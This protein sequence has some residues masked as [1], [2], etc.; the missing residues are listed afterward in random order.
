MDGTSCA[1]PLVA[2]VISLLNSARLAQNKTVL[3][4]VSPLLYR[5][6]DTSSTGNYNA[7]NYDPSSSPSSSSS[8]PSSGP[9]PFFK[10]VV[11]G[12]NRC[13]AVYYNGCCE[14]GFPALE[15]FDVT[16]GLVSILM[17][18]FLFPTESNGVSSPQG[19]PQYETM[20]AAVTALP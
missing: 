14:D 12:N 20:A 18:V 15:G 8:S 1:T 11:K 5:L 17:I 2:G 9:S 6:F 19:L 7:L 4:P 3:G 16:T 10:D 13:L